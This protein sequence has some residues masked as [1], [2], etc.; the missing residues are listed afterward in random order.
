MVNITDNKK[1]AQLVIEAQNN[2]NDYEAINPNSLAHIIKQFNDGEVVVHDEV[3]Q[4]VQ[5]HINDASVHLTEARVQEITSDK[6]TA[7]NIKAGANISVEVDGNDVTISTGTIPQ[8]SFL[9]QD[10]VIPLDETITVIKDYHPEEYGDY[11]LGIRANI[12]DTT[13]FTL[14]QNIK[15]AD[16][17]VTVNYGS[18]TN[19]VFISANPIYYTAGSGIN[20]TDNV[21][22]N[23]MPDKSV[24]I[25]AG[26]NITVE[27]EYPSFKISA[28]DDLKVSPWEPYTEYTENTMVTHNGG[29]F[30]CREDHKSNGRIIG[31]IDENDN[32][33]DTETAEIIGH[34]V[35]DTVYDND[36]Q[37]IGK[38]VDGQAVDGAFEPEYWEMLAA[39]SIKRQIF[40]VTNPTRTLVLDEVMPSED[41]IIINVAGVMQNSE[42]YSLDP[43]G[44]TLK[45]IEPIPANSIVEV[46]MMGNTILNLH[47]ETANV[48]DWAEDTSYIVGN[49]VIYD[50]G[51]YKCIEKHISGA[52]FDSHKWELVAGY[53]K[54][55]EFFQ[56]DEPTT[57]IELEHVVLNKNDIMV[58]VG[59][60]LLMSNNY[61]IEPDGKTITF[62]DPIEANAQIEVVVFGHSTVADTQVPSPTVLNAKDMLR[63]NSN[64]NGYELITPQQAADNIGLGTL[65][66]YDGENNKLV[67]VNNAATD[68]EYINANEAAGLIGVRRNVE[69]FRTTI[70]PGELPEPIPGISITADDSI[71]FKPGTIMSQDGSVMIRI[72]NE[73]TK[74]IN[75]EY[76]YGNN[77]GLMIGVIDNEWE[78]PIMSS[79]TNAYCS[80]LVSPEQGVVNDREGWRAMDGRDDGNGWMSNVS[81]SVW[82]FEC[83]YPISINRVVFKNT[84]SGY[85]T[86]YSKDI[87]LWSANIINPQETEETVVGSFTAVNQDC[88]ESDVTIENPVYGKVFGLTVKNSYGTAIG[89][90]EIKLYGSYAS[91]LLP[92]STGY[93]Y[94][95]SNEDGTMTD[96]A[97]SYLYM[98]EFAEQLPSP[99]VKYGLIGTFDLDEDAHVLRTYPQEDLNE[100]YITQKVISIDTMNII[101]PIGSTYLTYND[102]CPLQSLGLGIWT[103]E[104]TISSN[105]NVFKRVA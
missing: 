3:E 34:V 45:F 66:N 48:D 9:T 2:P 15:P 55:S 98:D 100:A 60:T 24:E 91:Y 47:D 81:S 17:S 4:T 103:L 87:D 16:E 77:E 37:E 18:R 85:S 69:G 65:A 27:G 83:K 22:T 53:A 23:T 35:G 29:L 102:S 82:Q 56:S 101:Y 39:W 63:V 49:I 62:V 86:E 57:S 104:T 6:I 93:I 50:N 40:N 51:L 19:D 68:Y 43:D 12:P 88:G 10:K 105:I 74:K 38:V 78:S 80:I 76:G 59:N 31:V 54:Y 61:D 14:P 8:E 42:N 11:A 64:G 99:F 46:I 97:T 95:I 79:A 75:E 28:K 67:K 5:D 25:E 94:A 1:V 84:K 13:H 44:Q 32:V 33:I 21:I 41:S 71:T 92:N 90:K 96:I 7:E 72:P 20:I 30:I 73:I 58:N 89:A 70:I 26:P 52:S 36:D